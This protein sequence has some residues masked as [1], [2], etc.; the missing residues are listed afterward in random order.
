M[1]I[2]SHTSLLILERLRGTVL[3][4]SPAELHPFAVSSM[5]CQSS[6]HSLYPQE[7]SSFI[8][9]LRNLRNGIF[10]YYNIYFLDNITCTACFM[11]SGYKC[12]QFALIFPKG[13]LN[14]IANICRRFNMSILKPPSSTR[15]SPSSDNPQSGIG[16][17][18]K[19]WRRR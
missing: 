8:P 3:N 2:F 19:R 11:Y 10:L 9:Y 14:I 15:I 13:Y 1:S 12:D 5:V 18:S 16:S 4:C 7:V 6:S 17:T